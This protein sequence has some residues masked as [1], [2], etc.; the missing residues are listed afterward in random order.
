MAHSY[1][2]KQAQINIFVIR[3]AR[4]AR[5]IIKNTSWYGLDRIFRKCFELWTSRR[6]QGR[7][8]ALHKTSW[9]IE[10]QKLWLLENVSPNKPHTQ[11]LIFS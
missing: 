5:S 10:G 3:G 8:I 2:R 6:H 11:A 7:L 1:A 4:L 9:V